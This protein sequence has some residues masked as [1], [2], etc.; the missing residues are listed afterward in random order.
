MSTPEYRVQDAVLLALG[1]LPHV[2]L[3][4]QQ[5]GRVAVIPW[6]QVERV[7]RL[8]GVRARALQLAPAGAADLAGIVREPCPT[9]GRP[10]GR[11]LQVEV[12]SASG[13]QSEAQR[14]FQHVYSDLG[15]L[16]VVVRSPEEALAAVRRP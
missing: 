7:L 6:D 15:A 1:A 8:T 2:R 11:C 3:H 5:A 4:R 16:Y 9:C 13:R 12:K 14:T 10:V